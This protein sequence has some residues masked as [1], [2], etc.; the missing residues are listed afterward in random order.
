MVPRFTASVNWLS[1]GA[2]Q[3]VHGYHFA[4]QALPAADGC[5]LHPPRTWAAIYIK[6]IKKLRLGLLVLSDYLGWV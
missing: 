1:G 5:T 3:I 6:L 4:V 2:F